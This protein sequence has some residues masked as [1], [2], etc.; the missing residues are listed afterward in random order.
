MKVILIAGDDIVQSRRR[1]SAYYKRA[2]ERSWDVIRIDGSNIAVSDL[3]TLVKSRP[4]LSAG[5]LVVVENLFS[6]NRQAKKIFAKI[7]KEAKKKYLSDDINTVLVF[8]E[9]K[10]IQLSPDSSSFSRTENFNLKSSLFRFLDNLDPNN[11]LLNLQTLAEAKKENPPE[12]ILVMLARHIRLLVLVKAY[13]E[14]VKIGWQRRKLER[15]AA[16]FSLDTLL[17][18]HTQLTKLDKLQKKSSLPLDIAA[19]LDLIVGRF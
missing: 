15:Q 12:K 18:L 8:W 3:L 10:K 17:A 11:K 16:K 5:Q 6:K 2:Y 14:S 4:L 7:N 9:P 1:L 19:S 13:P